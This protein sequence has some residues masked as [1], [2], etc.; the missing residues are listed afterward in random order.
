MENSA[1][2][3]IS[4][5]HILFTGK[6]NPTTITL[7]TAGGMSI[8]TKIV[9]AICLVLTNDVNN[10]H[11]YTIPE[12]VFDPNIPINIV[13]VPTLGKLFGNNADVNGHLV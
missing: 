1:T 11:V 3:I 10:H 8:K 12:C 13:G 6:F 5:E 2:A 9:G 7:E 4:N